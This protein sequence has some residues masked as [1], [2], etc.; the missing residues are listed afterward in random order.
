MASNNQEF[1]S[2]GT[3]KKLSLQYREESREVK[4]WTE[5]PSD[6][7]IFKII[8]VD[9]IKNGNFGDTLLLTFIDKAGEESK[10]FAS[11]PLKQDIEKELDKPKPRS[12]FFCSLGQVKRPNGY[13]KNEYD[14]CFK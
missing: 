13:L 3:F 5:L 12:I 2:R 7:T 8:N 4:H 14:I 11:K 9:K 1:I 10:V 6:G